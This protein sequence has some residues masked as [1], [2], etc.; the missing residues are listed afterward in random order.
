[1][2]EVGAIAA[3]FV[4][5][6]VEPADLLP[7]AELML[8]A[9][10]D[11]IDYEGERLA[12]AIEEVQRYLS[13]TSE[14]PALLGHSVLVCTGARLCCACLVM[15]WHRRQ[16]PSIGY[17]MC[18]PAWKRRSLASLALAESLRRLR[19]AGFSQVRAVITE[20]NVAS[21]RLFSSAGFA[22]LASR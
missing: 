8:E 17:V 14:D 15:K 18:H 13:P 4:L 21:E 22:R 11:T 20:G 10:R 7:L 6:T 2:P 1:M 9:F 3:G 12:E 16:C 19:K 5:R